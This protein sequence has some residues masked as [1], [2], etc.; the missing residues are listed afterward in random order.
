MELRL[1]YWSLF[2]QSNDQVL[3]LISI[4]VIPGSFILGAG[5]CIL[6]RGLVCKIRN[7]RA[8]TISVWMLVMSKLYVNLIISYFFSNSMAKF[9]VHVTGTLHW[10][11]IP[12]NSAVPEN[13]QTHP[14][15][16]RRNFNKEGCCKW[17]KSFREK[18]DLH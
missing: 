1:L 14:Q 3:F 4:S 18:E 5:M 8:F 16:V 15:R 11:N 2:L 9:E 13:I 7:S 6:C 17:P 10:N 12:D